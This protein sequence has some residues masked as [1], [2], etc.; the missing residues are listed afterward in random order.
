[1]TS[2][3]RN[4]FYLDSRLARRRDAGGGPAARGA[5]MATICLQ[6][7]A[8]YIPSCAVSAKRAITE[9]RPPP[10]ARPSCDRLPSSSAPT[11]GAAEIAADSA[12]RSGL[13]TP[14]DALHG[15]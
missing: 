2:A 6:G 13:W 7:V 11:P 8:V 3:T 4:A 12:G 14:C 10:A 1:M 5:I 15:V 9:R